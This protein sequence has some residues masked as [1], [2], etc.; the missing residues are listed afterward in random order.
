MVAI[1][2][3]PAQLLVDCRCLLGEGIVWCPRREVLWWTD[4]QSSRLWM[5]SPGTRE[6]RAWDLSDRLGCLALCESGKLL[7][8]FS[9]NLVL[10]DVD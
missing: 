3:E 5:H 9:K 7:L 2:P 10:A 4:I 8:G 1:N 6:T